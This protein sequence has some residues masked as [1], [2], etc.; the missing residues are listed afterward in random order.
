MS[1]APVVADRLTKIYHDEA[2][3]EVRAVDGVDFSCARGEIL[4]LLGANGAG[5]TTTLRMLSTVL[6]PTRGTARVAAARTAASSASSRAAC[7]RAASSALVC[8]SNCTRSGGS[9]ER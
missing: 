1:D 2:R 7:A 8:S 5:K 6:A 4:G 9:A 3:G